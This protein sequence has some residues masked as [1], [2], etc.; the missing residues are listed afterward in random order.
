MNKYFRR[1]RVEA[2]INFFGVK[3]GDELKKFLDDIG[4][5]IVEDLKLVVKGD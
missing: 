2:F 5:E 1:N 4:V 3:Y